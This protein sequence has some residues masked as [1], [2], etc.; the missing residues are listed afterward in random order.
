M[1]VRAGEG[2]NAMNELLSFLL[3]IAVSYGII[4]NRFIV[5]FHIAVGSL[6]FGFIGSMFI[7]ALWSLIEFVWHVKLTEYPLGIVTLYL[8][9]VFSICLSA[10]FNHE[11]KCHGKGQSR[12]GFFVDGGMPIGLE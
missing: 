12:V 1:E 9:A 4:T 6:F 5:Y 3:L 2:E 11:Y 10:V 7:H 8:A